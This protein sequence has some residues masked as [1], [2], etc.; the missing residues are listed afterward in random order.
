MQSHMQT[1]AAMSALTLAFATNVDSA[2]KSTPSPSPDM[3]AGAL[4]SFLEIAVKVAQVDEAAMRTAAEAPPP[5]LAEAQKWHGLSVKA[6]EWTRS[7]LAAQQDGALGQLRGLLEAQQPPP[8]PAPAPV[9][10]PAQQPLSPAMSLASAPTSAGSSLSTPEL[11]L[12]TP[13]GTWYPS[14]AIAHKEV[15]YSSSVR[16]SV[17]PS[18]AQRAAFAAA[19]LEKIGSLRDDLERLKHFPPARCLIVRRIKRLDLRSPALIKERLSSFGTVTEVLVAHSFERKS[20]K[21]RVDRVRPAALGFVIMGSEEDAKAVLAAG[22]TIWVG[23]VDVNVSEFEPFECMKG[24]DESTPSFEPF[25]CMKEADVT[26]SATEP[27]ECM[28]DANP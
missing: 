16:P 8:L 10:V 7:S 15:P 23:D 6:L 2:D 13:P 28:N 19:G 4:K 12:R 5:E 22:P 14:P 11:N 24:A 26:V 3:V 9:A 20:T 21:C 27:F 17:P 25:E 1:S 18:P